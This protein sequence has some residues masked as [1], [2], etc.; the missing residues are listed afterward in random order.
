[1]VKFKKRYCK[2]IAILVFAISLCCMETSVVFAK[3]KTE[4][5]TYSIITL[6][7]KVTTP[8]GLIEVRANVVVNDSY[9][10]IID[11]KNAYVL[12]WLNGTIF[13]PTGIDGDTISL[14]QPIIH[15]NGSYATITV[16]YMRNGEWTSEVC[17][18][19]P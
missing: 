1:M 3:S 4:M 14:G 12:S 9:N 6:D 16:T 17:T 18:F 8:S 15:D 7:S 11:I 5:S 10:K 19:Y 2:R 13:A